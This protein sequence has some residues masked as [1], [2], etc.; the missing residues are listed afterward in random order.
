MFSQE[1]RPRQETMSRP[2][3]VSVVCVI[4]DLPLGSRRK[5][6][7]IRRTTTGVVTRRFSTE[8]I[9]PPD[10]NTQ[11][12]QATYPNQSRRHCSV[13]TMI[14]ISEWERTHGRDRVLCTYRT[15][16]AQLYLTSPFST[17][18]TKG[19]S[20][21]PRRKRRTLTGLTIDP[22]GQPTIGGVALARVQSYEAF[23]WA[24]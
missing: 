10:T 24:L 18:D 23:W 13:L 3:R 4:V 11:T 6:F 15:A 5:T 1:E 12:E 8:R 22:P 7:E 19:K 16:R 2:A 17:R 9:S 21:F 14:I 20:S